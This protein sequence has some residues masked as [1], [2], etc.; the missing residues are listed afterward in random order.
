[1]KCTH[2]RSNNALKYVFNIQVQYIKYKKES[3]MEKFN[4]VLPLVAFEILNIIFIYFSSIWVYR[5]QGH[6]VWN[7]GGDDTVP[8]PSSTG[9]PGGFHNNGSR[10]GNDTG[11]SPR[12]VTSPKCYGEINQMNRSVILYVHWKEW[13]SKYQ[14]P[15]TICDKLKDIDRPMFQPWLLCNIEIVVH[16]LQNGA[17]IAWPQLWALAGNRSLVG[18]I[19]D[20][21]LEGVGVALNFSGK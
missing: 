3:L 21:C 18:R 11:R 13:I 7:G 15:S 1:M 4:I 14:S 19:Q 8:I 12:P 6:A 9:E 10:A 5:L 2:G 16:A 17:C 20:F